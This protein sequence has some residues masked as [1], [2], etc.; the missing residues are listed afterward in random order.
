MMRFTFLLAL[1]VAAAVTAGCAESDNSAGYNQPKTQ[2]PIAQP[3]A[4]SMTKMTIEEA[5][6]EA[7]FKVLEPAYLPEGVVYVETRYIEFENQVFVVLQYRYSGTER[8]FQIDEYLPTMPESD[9]GM[10]EVQVGEHRAQ[11]SFQ[12]G[13]SILR[14][15]QGGTRL[16]L[17]GAI[18]ETEA[19]KVASSF[20]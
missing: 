4:R 14:W 19:L 10:Q 6:S 12:H 16:M 3:V 1:L 5:R 7:P 8:Y 15:T 18:N 20:K 9:L 17:N 2:M 11:A 13:L